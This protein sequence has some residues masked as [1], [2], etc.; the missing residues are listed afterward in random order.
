MGKK[1]KKNQKGVKNDLDR[2]PWIMPSKGDDSKACCKFCN[3]EKQAHLK[4]V[5]DH[6]ETKKHKMWC[7][8]TV[9]AFTVRKANV[10]DASICDDRCCW[11]ATYVTCHTSSPDKANIMVGRHHSM[12][13]LLKQKQPNLRCVCHYLD[14]VAQKAIQ[15]LL[16]N[17]EY[18][19]LR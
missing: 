8:P 9:K 17:T 10:S 19:T 7:L 16:S 14:I 18:F 3:T 2:K 4:D 6:A 15:Q 11:I 13:I 5:K 1:K 12:Y